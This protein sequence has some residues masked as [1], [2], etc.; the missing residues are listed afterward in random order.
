MQQTHKT[1][2]KQ[3]QIIELKCPLTLITPK[4][5]VTA[6]FLIDY[7]ME[8]NLHWVTF[9]NETGECWCYLNKDIKLD[10]NITLNRQ[11]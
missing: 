11:Y 6:H 9:H 7:G 1:I 4:G 5:K 2:F 8:Q 3:M 10:Q